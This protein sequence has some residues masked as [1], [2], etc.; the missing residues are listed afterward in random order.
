MANIGLF[1]CTYITP[2]INSN[3]KIL[4]WPKADQPVT[5]LNMSGLEK[6]YDFFSKAVFE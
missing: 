5:L 1:E 3:K 4:V 6:E 2:S